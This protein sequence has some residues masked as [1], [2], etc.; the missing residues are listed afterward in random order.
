MGK[1]RG[2]L[3][4]GLAGL[5]LVSAV[6][7]VPAAAAGGPPGP[8]MAWGF[9]NH[10]QI[11]DG[12]LTNRLVPVAVCAVGQT[13]P[14]PG[15]LTSV[16]QVA[17]GD[18]ETSAALLSDGTVVAWGN[19]AT[20]ALGDGTT[21]ERRTPVRV[22]AV[23]QSVPCASFLTGVTSIAAGRTHML[24]LLSDGT[25]VGWGHNLQGQLGDGT[26]VDRHTPVRVCA[27]GQSA[28]CAAFLTGVSGLVGG[29][30][31][32][33]A[34]LTDGSVASWGD[35]A[36]GQ[37]GNGTT[38]DAPTP[39][40]VCAVGQSA[41][42]AAFLSG[43]TSLGPGLLENSLAVGPGGV[44]FGWGNNFFGQLGDGTTTDRP[45]PV[46]A[47]AVGQAA[48]CASFLTGITSVAG[49]SFSHSLALG[50]GGAVLA[51]G[52]N[53]SGKLGDGTGTDRFT[54]VRVCAVGQTAPCAAF[55][56]GATAI[57]AGTGHSVAVL[58][59][60]GALAWGSNAVGQ[61]GDGTTNN[62]SVPGPVCANASCSSL[63]G[64]V[65]SVIGGD[66]H[67]LAI[68]NPPAADIQVRLNASS[69]LLSSVITY[70]VTGIN[71]GPGTVTSGTI[72]LRVPDPTVSVSA[73]GCTYNAPSRTVS[74]PTGQLIA[75]QASTHTVRATIG[76]LT[77][78]LPLPATATRAASTPAD[79]NASNDQ[80]SASCLVVT[81]LII[82]C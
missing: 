60:G 64:N 71:R 56:T 73:P 23:G 1:A 42:C 81:G 34:L 67:T 43:V 57:S 22:C 53:G 17:A 32:S 49:G 79:P 78:G 36:F 7:M 10:G 24:A 26:G 51:W 6:L 69:S 48:P 77:V 44:V 62:R 70:T 33:V 5:S 29:D 45:T 63:L 66:D 19:N 2:R 15:Q 59:S 74:C 65:T 76:T 75:K 20:G 58:A 18:D 41:P 47:C 3:L 38:V 28:P 39:V 55:L 40:R 31:H 82:L 30:D 11:G 80:A 13:A 12:T 68:I 35:N 4:A 27:V 72:T 50:A 9:N 46:Q 54:P 21:T 37:L 52:S 25:V 61:L 14:C 8:V 16:V